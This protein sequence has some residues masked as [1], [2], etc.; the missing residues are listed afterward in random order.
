MFDFW[1]LLTDNQTVSLMISFEIFE[2]FFN[3]ETLKRVENI[4]K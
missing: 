4:T 2:I 1:I 3:S